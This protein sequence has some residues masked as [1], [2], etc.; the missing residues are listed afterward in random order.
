MIPPNLCARLTRWQYLRIGTRSLA[1]GKQLG[2]V[3]HAVTKA[4][5]WAG[6]IASPAHEIAACPCTI[7]KRR[8]L[9]PA[10]AAPRRTATCACY[11]GHSYPY[12][13]DATAATA[14]ATDTAAAGSASGAPSAA[15]ATSGSAAAAATATTTSPRKLH[16]VAKVFTIDEMEGREAD[17]CEFFFTESH[18]LARREVRPWLNVARR[19]G[20][21][22]CA[23]RQRKSQSG[24]SQRRY[25]G[26]CYSLLFRSLLHPLHGRILQHC[27]KEIRESDPTLS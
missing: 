1:T 15:S 14:S 27:K 3:R 10:A 21:C 8:R 6:S 9:A 4:I 23:S 11:P 17:V 7:R 16:A 24:R 20:C 12:P 2:Q 18:H 5:N 26:F 25:G 13:A 22:R 19:Y